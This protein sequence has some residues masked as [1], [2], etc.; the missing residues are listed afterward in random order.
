MDDWRAIPTAV[1]LVLVIVLGL[2]A[3]YLI[4]TIQM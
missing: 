1:R 2:A 4:D 3:L